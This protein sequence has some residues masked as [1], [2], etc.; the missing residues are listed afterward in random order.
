M[1]TSVKRIAISGYYGFN[2]SGDEAVL[3]SIL[4]A[5]QEQGERQG[6]TFVPVVLSVNPAETAR[7]YGV[8]AVHR[9]KPMEVWQALRNADGLISGGGSLLQDETSPK[10]IPY[11]IAVIRLAQWMGKP[12]FIYSQGI[13]PVHRRLF[14]G[15]I[16]SAFQ[17]SSFITVR[18]EESKALLGK[19]G[20]SPSEVEVVPDPVMGLP[21]R[22]Q[23][24]QT[25]SGETKPVIGV[26]VR[27]WN[28][29]RS[30]LRAVAESLQVVLEKSDAVIRFLPFHLPSDEKAS[31]YV[32]EQMGEIY[33]ERL[34]LAREVTH[35]Q[36]MLAEVAACQ[37][38]LGMRLH[39]LIYAA[40]QYVPMVGLSYDP[41]IDQFLNRLGMKSA[42]TTKQ[43]RSE[44]L[45]Q[46]TLGMLADGASWKRDKRQAIEQLKIEAG[47]PA[48]RIASFFAKG[49][50]MQ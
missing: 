38:L 26:S 32:M 28:E 47:R 41:K 35:P 27:F 18:D 42:G 24:T 43:P 17:R 49:R 33:K 19:M 37:V 9:M 44:D 13:G 25:P 48:E 46:E 11:Y 12:V 29:D 4:L 30:E 34:S 50:G 8:E 1:G 21:M 14:F 40:S 23:P 15:W 31:L 5:L 2:N 22:G 39:S 3:Q 6:V 10:T 36:D 16:R 20:I 45:A 7:T